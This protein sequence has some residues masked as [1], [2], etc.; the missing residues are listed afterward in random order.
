VP[1]TVVQAPPAPPAQPQALPPTWYYCDRPPGYYPY[2]AECPSGWRAVPATPPPTAAAPA[3][4]HLPHKKGSACDSK[5]FRSL[6]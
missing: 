1:P 6:L 4:P 3:P 2:V 5:L